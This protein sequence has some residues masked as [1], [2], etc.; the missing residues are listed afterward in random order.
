MSNLFSLN[1]K[2]LL[3]GFIMAVI[4]ALLGSIYAIIQAG[5]IQWTWT[6]WQVPVYGAIL[7]GVSYLI[8]N[9]LTN[10]SG[11]PLKAEVK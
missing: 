11:Q 4:G 3:K 1:I 10:S 6:F 9:F 8:K 7:A 5:N 2:D